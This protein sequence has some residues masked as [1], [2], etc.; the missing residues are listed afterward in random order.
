MRGGVT[1]SQQGHVGHFPIIRCEFSPEAL[2]G[3][4]RCCP[5]PPSAQMV[6]ASI[7]LLR[8]LYIGPQGFT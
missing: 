4:L 2:L 3:S 1:M 7:G 8:S 5:A 6:K